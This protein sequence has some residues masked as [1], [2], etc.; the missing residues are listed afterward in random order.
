[1]AYGV[2]PSFAAIAMQVVES[3]PP[4]K[5]TTAFGCILLFYPVFWYMVAYFPNINRNVT[6][7]KH[8]IGHWLN[9]SPFSEHTIESTIHN[10]YIY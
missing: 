2:N 5:S 4:L 1:M 10:C 9:T 7:Y 8:Q 3:R 6:V